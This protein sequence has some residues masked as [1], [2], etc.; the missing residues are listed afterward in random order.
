MIRSNTSNIVKGWDLRLD[1]KAI[2]NVSLSSI[3]R[4]AVDGE[5]LHERIP[6]SHSDYRD[7]GTFRDKLLGFWYERLW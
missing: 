1:L 4:R 5:A 2:S 3:Y 7:W 6:G